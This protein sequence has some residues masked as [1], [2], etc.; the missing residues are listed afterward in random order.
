MTLCWWCCHPFENEPLHLPYKYDD[1]RDKFHTMGHFC[2]WSCM[3]AFNV[4][5]FPQHKSGLIGINITLMK[6]KMNDNK[7]ELIK[8]APSRY[9]LKAFGGTLTIEEFRK[10]DKSIVK[11][12]L[13]CDKVVFSD[14]IVEF[15]ENTT[16]CINTSKFSEKR[17]L[18][19]INNASHENQ[20]LKLKR[21]KPLKRN[22]NNLENTLGLF[23]KKK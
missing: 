9:C 5:H 18:D 11:T 8:M 23:S 15:K 16:Q 7:I 13:G 19:E 20:P 1:K 12:R 21:E 10:Y 2:S 6:K 14:T 4:D 22:K 3:K 17:K